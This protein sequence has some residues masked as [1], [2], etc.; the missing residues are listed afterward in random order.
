M[1]FGFDDWIYWQFFTITCTVD[2]NSSHVWRISHWSLL[3]LWSLYSSTPVRL[4][5]ASRV[6]SCLMLRPTVIRPVCFGMK[7]PSAAYDQIFV[8]VRQLRVC[9]C[10]ALSLTRGRVCRLQL[11]RAL[12]S[13]VNLCSESRGSRDHILRS[14]IR[15]FFFLAPPT[16]RRATVEVFDSC[17][18]ESYV[19]TDG[20]PSVLE[21]ST[22]LWLT[23]RFLLLW[24]RCGFDDVGLSLWREDGS[25]VC[26]CCHFR[27][28]VPWDSLLYFTVSD[29]RL[30]FSSPPTTRR[31]TVEVFDPASTR[32]SCESEPYVTTDGQPVSLSL[33]LRQT[34]SRPVCLGIKPPSGAYVQI[35][36]IVWQLR[37]CWFWAPS[38][39]RGRVC[40]LQLQLALASE[41]IT[42]PFMTHCGPQTEHTLERFVCWNLR[43][44]CHGNACLLNRCPATVYSASPRECA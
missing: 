7:H 36:I 1:G 4:T 9:W 27:V 32:I 26:N 33:T 39:T 16:T 37:V 43:I 42:C 30:P 11:L 17:E 24:D 44:R 20:Q 18:S 3:L 34:V 8:T 5:P 25:V 22:H 13:A 19:T 41:W 10:W 21:L 2:Y 6:D 29:S 23:T 14:Q 31:V 38:L 15:D 28:R 40:R 35:F 12:A